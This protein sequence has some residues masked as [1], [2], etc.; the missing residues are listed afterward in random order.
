MEL[1]PEGAG[2]NHRVKLADATAETG[3]RRKESP[4]KSWSSRAF[5]A[6]MSKRGSVSAL[7]DEDEVLRRE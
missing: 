5:H 4:L 3:E 6:I 2:A 7:E 1:F